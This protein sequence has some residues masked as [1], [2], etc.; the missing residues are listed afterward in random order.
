MEVA[1]KYWAINNS[2]ISICLFLS[3]DFYNFKM[4]A[5]TSSSSAT[6]AAID[7][8]RERV[9]QQ[10]E[11][12]N[13]NPKESLL[14]PNINSN[15][16]PNEKRSF[17]MSASASATG[18]PSTTRRKS[19]S[20]IF[21]ASFPE[22][23]SPQQRKERSKYID[24]TPIFEGD[25]KPD[26]SL[27]DNSSPDNFM[28][29]IGV[30]GY[31][32]YEKG[33]SKLVAGIGAGGV[34]GKGLNAI[35]A[36]LPKTALVTLGKSFNDPRHVK[37]GHSYRIA[38]KV[39]IDESRII[40]GYTFNAKP[41]QELK[42]HVHETDRLIDDNSLSSADLH[43]GISGS[44]ISISNSSSHFDLESEEV[45]GRLSP[46]TRAES[47]SPIP[48][49]ST[50][51][52]PATKRRVQLSSINATTLIT[53]GWRSDYPPTLGKEEKTASKREVRFKVPA[54]KSRA[55]T[56]NI[57]AKRSQP[58]S[59]SSGGKME[60]RFKYILY[61]FCQ[62]SCRHCFQAKVGCDDKGRS[63]H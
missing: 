29:S 59:N 16:Q 17:S 21:L 6:A 46:N 36:S 11:N 14:L 56:A 19:R 37:F 22:S 35:D 10:N 42:R 33:A 24:E 2:S 41:W 43:A 3:S 61:N 49:A 53:S 1:N 47:N 8:E 28:P 62:Y 18:L 12:T 15:L 9:Q 5:D 55:S 45:S 31:S 26:F 27:L 54:Q 25:M 51:I 40:N 60:S 4:M 23:M 38:R 48:T 57:S 63:D 34:V 13:N 58:S 50:S 30:P 52:I 20:S 7:D 32:N 44:K 39:D